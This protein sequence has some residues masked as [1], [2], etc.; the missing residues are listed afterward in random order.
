M[1]HEAFSTNSELTTEGLSTKPEKDTLDWSKK[2]FKWRLWYKIAVSLLTCS[3]S[4]VSFI[5]H[6]SASSWNSKTANPKNWR[7]ENIIFPVSILIPEWN[8]KCSSYFVNQ[9]T[10]YQPFSHIYWASVKKKE[11]KKNH[12]LHQSLVKLH[13]FLWALRPISTHNPGF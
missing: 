13:I 5:P 10:K 6:S 9:A 1:C 4:L 2:L 11:R 7:Q 8:F 3:L 12:L